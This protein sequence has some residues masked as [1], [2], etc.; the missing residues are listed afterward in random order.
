MRETALEVRGAPESRLIPLMEQL[1]QQFPELKLFSLPHL[2]D[3]DADRY[4]L[5]GFRGRGD[6]APAMAA[7]RAG[8]Q[9]QGVEFLRAV[10]DPP[11]MAWSDSA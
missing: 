10:L 9:E 3:T 1:G 2:G 7:L 5:L 6:L 4:I 11:L 8:L